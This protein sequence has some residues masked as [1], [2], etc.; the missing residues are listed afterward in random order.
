MR[1]HLPAREEPL[2]VGGASSSRMSIIRTFC[3]DAS[4]TNPSP[5]RSPGCNK[6]SCTLVQSVHPEMSTFRDS[7]QISHINWVGKC[8]FLDNF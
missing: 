2:Q 5:L 1:E 8:V 3:N 7:L 4:V 6:C